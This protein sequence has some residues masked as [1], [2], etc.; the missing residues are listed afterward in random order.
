[1]FS[2][3]FESSMKEKK[4]LTFYLKGQTIA[5]IVTKILS[6]HA[7]E[8]RNQTHSR[9]VIRIDCIDAIALN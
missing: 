2:D 8:V 3:L 1:M 5:G 6:Q 9:I 4:G 7:I